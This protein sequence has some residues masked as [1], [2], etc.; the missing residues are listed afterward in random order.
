MYMLVP[1]IEEKAPW[2]CVRATWVFGWVMSWRWCR[3]KW[4]RWRSIWYRS[5]SWFSHQ[6]TMLTSVARHKE[7]RNGGEGGNTNGMCPCRRKVPSARRLWI[8]IQKNPGDVGTTGLGNGGGKGT[9]RWNF[10]E[11]LSSGRESWVSP[12]I[13][14]DPVGELCGHNMEKQVAMSLIN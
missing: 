1:N 6:K 14:G 9:L 5:Q 2:K 7:A 11:D 4:K 13:A 10:R 3:E 8:G 12:G